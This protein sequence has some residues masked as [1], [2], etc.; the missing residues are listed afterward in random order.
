MAAVDP[1]ETADSDSDAE[2]GADQQTPGASLDNAEAGPG[3]STAPNELLV[4]ARAASAS[5]AAEPVQPATD[6]SDEED[7]ES[8]EE[9]LG[10]L[11]SS[12][13]AALQ[14]QRQAHSLHKPGRGGGE[15]F[16]FNS[17][18]FPRVVLCY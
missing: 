14:R 2:E 7:S 6:A 3:S 9:P 18:A 12:L 4:E 5:A 10:G 1:Y 11:A 13:L 16:A 17:T 8:D 15:L